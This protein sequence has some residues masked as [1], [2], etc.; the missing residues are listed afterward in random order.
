MSDL[1][2]AVE[3]AAARDDNETDTGYLDRDTVDVVLALIDAHSCYDPE[4]LAAALRTV[5]WYPD[6]DPD[7]FVALAGQLRA[8]LEAGKAGGE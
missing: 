6:L 2:R 3:A 8:A 7:D 5:G 1:R 4:T